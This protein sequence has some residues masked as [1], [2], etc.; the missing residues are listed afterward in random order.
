MKIAIPLFGHRVAPRFDCSQRLCLASIENQAI[1]ER[2]WL[3]V[4]GMSTSEKIKL[5]SAL[6]V[7]ILIC[8]GIDPQ[9]VR[10]LSVDGIRLFAWVT[11]EAEDALQ[12]LLAGKMDS[13]LMLGP[14]GRCQGRWRLRGAGPKNG[15]KNDQRQAM[16]GNSGA[17]SNGGRCCR[18]SPPHN[19]QK[20]VKRG[21][22]VK[23]G[24]D[25]NAEI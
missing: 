1:A 2:Q 19:A 23:K 20:I 14:G 21:K 11:G 4:R 8:G 24:G 12:Y 17:K 18:G 5:L 9:S 7:E 25:L 10:Q 6:G 13:G 22:K 15:C 16:S 3:V